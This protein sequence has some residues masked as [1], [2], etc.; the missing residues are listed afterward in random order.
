MN[1]QTLLLIS[2]DSELRQ[3]VEAAAPQ[4]QIHS[5]D[6]VSEGLA[7]W[8]EISPDLIIGEGNPHTLAPLLEYASSN[9]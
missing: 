2:K 8:S 5:T 7:L 6:R 3:L 4:T 9:A 1:L